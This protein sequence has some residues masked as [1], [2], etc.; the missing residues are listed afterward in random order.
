MDSKCIESIAHWNAKHPSVCVSQ[1]RAVHR[2]PKRFAEASTCLFLIIGRGEKPM[3]PSPPHSKGPGCI[4]LF[5]NGPATPQAQ[6]Q[7]PRAVLWSC[8]SPDVCVL[9]GL[10]WISRSTL[11]THYPPTHTPTVPTS[12][13]LT[14]NTHTHT[15]MSL[16]FL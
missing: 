15:T 5:L 13:P 16:L 6:G 4:Q 3:A 2:R 10:G 14:P 8:V 7:V 9:S 11:N 12:N 1:C